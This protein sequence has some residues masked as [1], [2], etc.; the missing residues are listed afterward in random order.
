MPNKI[1]KT[2]R[3]GL[4][5]RLGGAVSGTFIGLIL[6]FASFV[7]LFWNEGRIDLGTVAED[8]VSVD[9]SSEFASEYDGV[10]VAAEGILATT[11]EITDNLFLN[12][13][14]FIAAKRN[15]ETYAWVERT[16]SES[17]TKLGGSEET[18]TT[19][20]YSKQWVTNIPD[21]SQFEDPT[22]HENPT[23]AKAASVTI[24]APEARVGSLT[25]RPAALGL[26]AFQDLSLNETT[27]T[28]PDSAQ[29]SGKYLYIENADP[30]KPLVGDTRFSYDTV[31][32]GHEVVAFGELTGS[33][34][35][36]YVDGDVQLYRSFTSSRDEAIATL[37]TEYKTMLWLFRALGFL[38]MWF[39]LSSIFGVLFVLSDIL[40]IL[41]HLSR[42]VVGIATFIVSLIL[43]ALTILVGIIMHNLYLLIAL[44]A[45]VI[46]T[47]I[48]ILKKKATK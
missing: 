35:E 15:V 42:S 38:M 22:D 10:F 23:E 43:S 32:N 29:V 41:G 25:V 2:T 21:S 3:K 28:V 5:S 7:V 16:E 18:V 47:T 1:V 33:A 31:R 45:A 20:T 13:Q 24:Y 30:R 48:V 34:L 11:A 14:K 27:V 44:V 12:P 46:I 8:A 39:G 36:P 9:A 37:H 26:P 40:P 19:Y 17:E 6:F 4:G